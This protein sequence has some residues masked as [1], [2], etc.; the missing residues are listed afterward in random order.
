MHNK[1]KKH[2]IDKKFQYKIA[3]KSVI[4]PLIS[5]LVISSVLIFFASENNRKIEEINSNQAAI[6][7][8]F[9]SLP[10]LADPQN[11]L[12]LE[13]NK[14]FQMNLG[15]SREIQKNS[16]KMIYFLIIMTIVQTAIIFILAIVL[17]H[18]ISGPIYI[19]RRYLNDLKAGKKISPRPIRKGD[20]FK[21]FYEEFCDT[22]LKLAAKGKKKSR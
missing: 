19:M 18:K 15:K 10:Q 20:E 9:L 7:D 17:S 21:E 3:L 6:I 11:T 4:F 2:I 14:K 12:T 5:I 8:T 13:A 1:R 22:I 16:R